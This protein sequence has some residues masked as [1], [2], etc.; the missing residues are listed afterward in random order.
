MREPHLSDEAV[1]AF[2]DG[3]LSRLATERARRHV[4][5][6]AECAEAVAVQR[7]AVWALRAAPPPT[8]SRSLLDRLREVPSC[9]PIRHVPT[10]FDDRG[11][12]MFA[13]FAAAAFVKP[14]RQQ[15][16]DSPRGGWARPFAV[17]AAAAAVIGS[18]AAAAALTGNDPAPAHPADTA[19]TVGDVH[20]IHQPLEVWPLGRLG[21][22]NRP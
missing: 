19:R 21:G 16:D 4:S 14:A 22:G 6:C 7:E 10:T 3:A 1:A 15:S 2:A 5:G 13:T 18:V 9:T 17:G 8:P 20:Q 12:A 11:N